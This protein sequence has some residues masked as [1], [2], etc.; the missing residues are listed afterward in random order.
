MIKKLGAAGIL[1]TIL[2]GL[3]T[4]ARVSISELK[5]FTKENKIQIEKLELHQSYNTEYFK[6][7]KAQLKEINGKLDGIKNKL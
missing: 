6:D 3:F 7:I 4:E 5:D 1:I 2:G